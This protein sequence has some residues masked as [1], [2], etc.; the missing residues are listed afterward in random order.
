MKIENMF[1][2]FRF[3]EY[4]GDKFEISNSSAVVAEKDCYALKYAKNTL[5]NASGNKTVKVSLITGIPQNLADRIG[6]KF[7]ENDESYAIEITGDEINIYSPGSRG[8][9]YGVSTLKQLMESKNIAPMLLFDCPDKSVRGYRVYTPGKNSIDTFKRM[10]DTMIYYKYNSIIIEVGGA[11][12]YKKHPEI[13]EKWIEFC[14]EVNKTPYEAARIQ[15][16]GNGKWA[17]NSIHADNGAG[18]YIT[19]EQMR[20]I[21]E[22]CRERE[23]EVIPEVPS[24]SHSDYI[25]MAH[26]ELNER[27]EDKYPDTYCPSNP[28]SYE[29][30]FDILDE[31]IDVFNPNY[32]NIGHDECYTL[33]VCDKCK[34][35]DPVLLYT[36]DII[37]IHNYI[38]SKNIKTIMWGEKLYNAYINNA[39]GTRF[40]VG[41]TGS[42]TTPTLWRCRY[43]LPTDIIQLQWYW[44][45]C[46]YV[47]EKEIEE[48][49]FTSVYGNF[50]AD[51]L[52][53]YRKR[54]GFAAGGFVSNWGSPEEVYMQRNGQNYSLIT[55]A[56]I[57]WN[58]EYDNHMRA[59]LIELTKTELYQRYLKTLGE[60]IIEVT[61]TTD[62]HRP[63][64]VFYDGF[65]IVEEDWT[66]GNYI[67]TYTDKTTAKLPV[68]Y[69]YNIRTH[70]DGSATISDSTEAIVSANIEVMG[71]TYPIDKNGKTYYK[72][73]YK[74]PYPEKEIE[75]IV[76]EGKDGITVETL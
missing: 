67:V 29:I 52:K 20:D 53:D 58:S 31:V 54:I 34:G 22:Y 41:G 27:E 4:Y 17:K 5:A 37:K 49:G 44:S 46:S 18:S 60:S 11:M 39:D 16:S 32:I 51:A 71:A 23:L 1:F 35:L 65:Y 43:Y 62:H 70:S 66:I 2:E 59:Q 26:P 14:S 10:V 19:Q 8:L 48:L 63:Y 12:E 69:G 64:K 21:V 45:L 76:F 55:T 57:F 74:N 25:V 15:S 42:K 3:V 73:A 30:V 33:A 36:N 38:K 72:T 40:P 56:W 9:I 13:N 50:R 24:L 6:D 68:I 75:S 47:E 7:S 28:K 61:H